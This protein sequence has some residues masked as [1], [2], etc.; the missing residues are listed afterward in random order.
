MG[1]FPILKA[2]TNISKKLLQV[3]GSGIML[4][5]EICLIIGILHWVFTGQA[6]LFI[7]VLA[8]TL[9]WIYVIHEFAD[10]VALIAASIPGGEK[11][12]GIDPN[13]IRKG[14]EVRKKRQFFGGGDDNT[15][16]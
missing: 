1:K 11:F 9:V 12:F 14:D 6:A 5:L 10:M 4:A 3:A 8:V 16:K 13:L 2:L 15:K 7:L